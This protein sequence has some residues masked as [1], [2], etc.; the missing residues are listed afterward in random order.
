MHDTNFLGVALFLKALAHHKGGS[1][2]LAAIAVLR[3]VKID[4]LANREYQGLFME[5]CSDLIREQSSYLSTRFNA[6]QCVS[7]ASEVRVNMKRSRSRVSAGFIQSRSQML[8]TA[9]QRYIRS[10]P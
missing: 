5:V 1:Q 7:W 8:S 2:R 3:A 9:L 10:A 6:A 4:A